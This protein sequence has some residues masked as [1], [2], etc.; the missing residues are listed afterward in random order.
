MTPDADD[1]LQGAVS[2]DV[3]YESGDHAQISLGFSMPELIR[4]QSD[5]E[6]LA[7]HGLTREDVQEVAAWIFQFM[8]DEQKAEAIQSGF[9]PRPIT[10]K[11]RQREAKKVR[12]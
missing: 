10:K 9:T 1:R 2:L 8:T 6:Q 7:Q 11:R 5:P 3:E 4:L 12:S